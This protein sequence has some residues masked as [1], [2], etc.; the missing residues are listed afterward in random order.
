MTKEAKVR[1]GESSALISEL[2]A[3]NAT[4]REQLEVERQAHAEAR[5][6]HRWPGREDVGHRSRLRAARATR[7]RG[8]CLAAPLV[9]Q[10]IERMT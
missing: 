10:A 4:L 5:A 8:A 7:A 6:H 3:H 2:R 9:A 1:T